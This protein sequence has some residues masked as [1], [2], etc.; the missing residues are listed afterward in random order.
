M[1]GRQDVRMWRGVGTPKRTFRQT[2]EE[3]HTELN[4]WQTFW[5][6]K[7]RIS[8][9]S[10]LRMISCRISGGKSRMLVLLVSIVTS[11]RAKF[12]LCHNVNNGIE[13][14]FISKHCPKYQHKAVF[15][16]CDILLRILISGSRSC[17]LLQWHL[18][19]KI[20]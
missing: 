8:L 17:Y 3:V 12:Y 15:W 5:F 16:V 6:F 9:W 13:P 20:I 7:W 18:R 4:L 19:I 1:S 2:L 10:R 14:V 11:E